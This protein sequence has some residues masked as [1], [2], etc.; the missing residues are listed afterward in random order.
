MIVYTFNL[1]SLIIIPTIK[2]TARKGRRSPLGKM[3]E[4]VR[5]SLL[6]G[7]DVTGREVIF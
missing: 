5:R 7:I 6:S 2:N 4:E 1:S 3:R